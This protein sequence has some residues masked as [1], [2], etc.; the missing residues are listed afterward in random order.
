MTQDQTLTLLQGLFDCGNYEKGRAFI[1][2]H[3]AELTAEFVA[4]LRAESFRL[5]EEPGGLAPIFAKLA[6]AAA[7][8]L[9]DDYEIGMSLYCE[10][11]IF[12]RLEAHHKAIRVFKEAESYFRAAQESKKLADCLYDMAISYAELAQFAQATQILEEV[13]TYQSTEEE[14]NETLA[15]MF[16]L[17][18]L[19]GKSPL[20]VS[21]LIMARLI[22]PHDPSSLVSSDK[23]KKQQMPVSLTE[24]SWMELSALARFPELSEQIWQILSENQVTEAAMRDL[25]G[26]VVELYQT[27]NQ[28]YDL[29]TV[30]DHA[31]QVADELGWRRWLAELTHT[32]GVTYASN[33]EFEEAQDFFAQ[34]AKLWADEAAHE[35]EIK[36]LHD[37]A[38]AHLVT[39]DAI[40][41]KRVFEDALEVA[42]VHYLARLEGRILL[43]LG[44]LFFHFAEDYKSADHYYGQA[45]ELYAEIADEDGE[46]QVQNR[47]VELNFVTES[48][49]AKQDEVDAETFTI[50]EMSLQEELDEW[51]SEKKATQDFTQEAYETQ[52]KEGRHPHDLKWDSLTAL[53]AMHSHLG[54][55]QEAVA[56]A[57]N[58]FAMAKHAK[59]HNKRVMSQINLAYIYYR[60]GD[61]EQA[62]TLFL[63][64]LEDAERLLNRKLEGAALQGVGLV[65][66][67]SFEK[68]DCYGRA[69]KLFRQ[70]GHKRQ[71][72]RLLTNTAVAH[73]EIAEFHQGKGESQEN[74]HQAEALLK[75]ALVSWQELDATNEIA[76]VVAQQAKL[77]LIQGDVQT[78]IKALQQA[79]S[80]SQQVRN[81]ASQI[82]SRHQLAQAYW[83]GGQ[84]ETALST[85]DQALALLEARF[86][87]LVA[88]SLQTSFMGQ[89]YLLYADAVRWAT[90][91]E[92]Q[93]D[94]LQYVERSRS[95]A[96]LDLMGD[97]EIPQPT[98]IQGS[99]LGQ[100]ELQARRKLKALRLQIL[101]ETGYGNEVTA[102][103]QQYADINQELNQ[104]LDQLDH[105]TD[106]IAAYIA[107]RRSVPI[108][109]N[110]V[111]SCLQNV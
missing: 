30:I 81:E 68:F 27:N 11:T 103:W 79:L 38:M 109:F 99:D 41:A 93:S 105:K 96:F 57:L 59:N 63:Y 20:E 26:P 92:R 76:T 4:S 58:A 17:M 89:S 74:L 78:A 25:V 84:Q 31:R 53:A 50:D 56:Y 66:R 62:R 61:F 10:G 86:D 22:A 15:F 40:R 72:A 54:H 98:L 85:L 29:E 60:A 111:K 24:M 70:L 75:N 80:L 87:T 95:R 64:S 104:L 83:K 37:L 23:E 9:G 45:G 39:G 35:E 102:F 42:Q 43:G 73:L 14:R 100:Q 77:H 36:S 7:V 52:L 110:E 97:A 46:R 44:D 51:F 19:Q 48:P 107:L 16:K 12:T 108:T 33:E 101:Q 34:A 91:K 21:Q 94:A 5:L 6:V 71:M 3:R 55:V 82:L 67:D 32:Q 47:L 18:L 49:Q 65:A 88:E 90:I 8:A 2:E 28:L 69:Y 1:R 106:E 13:L